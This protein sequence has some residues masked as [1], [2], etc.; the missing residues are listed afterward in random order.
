MDVSATDRMLLAALQD[1]LPLTAR[2][3]ADVGAE[4]GLSERE[5]IGRLES[6]TSRGVI[7]RFGL[8]VRHHENGYR[9]NA[10]VTWNVPDALVTEIGRKLAAFSFVT[11][12]YRRAR[13][14]PAWPY[15]LYCMIHGKD[16]E[17]VESA[18]RTLIADSGLAAYPHQVL[19]SRRRFKQRGAYFGPTDTQAMKEAS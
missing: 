4:I 12:C 19:F 1:G 14:L 7:K 18:I 6:L 16:R 17:T 2:P 5:V 15:N 9:A 3:Y 13:R 10:M 11:L 8:V